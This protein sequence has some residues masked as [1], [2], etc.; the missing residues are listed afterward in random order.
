MHCGSTGRGLS[1]KRDDHAAYLQSRLQAVSFLGFVSKE[2]VIASENIV[3]SDDLSV[4]FDLQKLFL[5][6]RSKAIFEIVLI[7]TLNSLL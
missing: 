3:K 4:W 5:I 2:L 7:D 6:Y 1:T